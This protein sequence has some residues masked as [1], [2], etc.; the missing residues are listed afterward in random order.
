MC[1]IEQQKIPLIDA[2]KYMPRIR[3][4]FRIPPEIDPTD[5]ESGAEIHFARTVKV[6]AA[7]PS[8]KKIRESEPFP[9]GRGRGVP[10]LCTATDV[11]RV[12]VRASPNR[13][14]PL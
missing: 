11:L 14:R 1:E 6:T 5:H 12:G 3:P 10:A 2:E 13:S 4:R 7:E 9:A 8:C